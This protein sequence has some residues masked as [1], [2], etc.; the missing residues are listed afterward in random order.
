MVLE[1]VQV[2]KKSPQTG[3]I[4]RKSVATYKTGVSMIAYR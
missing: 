3:E 2:T 1:S 4:T